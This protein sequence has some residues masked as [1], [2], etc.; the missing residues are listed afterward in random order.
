MGF[1]MGTRLLSV[2]FATAV[3]NGAAF[4]DTRSHGTSTETAA[5]SNRMMRK[6][7]VYLGIL[8]DPFPTLVGVNLGY[9]A[10]DFMR[11][12]GGLGRVSATL[13]ASEASATTLGAGTRFFV[14]GWNLS[15]VAGL[16]FAYVSVSQT[17]GAAV[18]VSNFGSSAAH[19]YATLGFDWQAASG[20]NVGAGYN[21]SFK[22][23][24][25]GLPYLNLGWYFDLI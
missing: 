10:F 11:I 12:T 20:F 14:P 25:G 2:I 1:S 4:A 24:V 13:G 22:G 6:A 19:I 23:G 7:G 15:P 3:I 21:L 18:S 17:G 9:N 8:G 5:Q 16:S